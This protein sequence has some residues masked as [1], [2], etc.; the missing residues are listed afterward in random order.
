MPEPL[1]L[2]VVTPERQLV[3][4]EV[5]SVDVP[6]K[7]GYL[8]ILP[9]HA[10]FVGLLG[11]GFLSYAA[12]GRRRYLSVSGGFIE[13][14]QD[15]VRILADVAERAEEVDVARAQAALKRA[16]EGLAKATTASA[17][18]LATATAAQ[19]RANSRIAAAERK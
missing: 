13:V 2:E 4:E 5:E 7:A 8:G 9:G 18:D 3:R 11:T 10:A 14:L 6:G 16:Q 19:E 12:G 17:E 15:T 1:H